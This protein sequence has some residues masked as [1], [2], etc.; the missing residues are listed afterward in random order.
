MRRP[1][2]DF[3]C[4]C[5][6]GRNGGRYSYKLLATSKTSTMQEELQEAFDA[7]FEYR[8]QTVFKST[9]GGQEV[10]CILER[11]KD[12]AAQRYD[13]KLLATSKTSN[14]RSA[15]MTVRFAGV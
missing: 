15:R 11:D 13:Y 9:S 3:D 8:G 6:G 12:A 5:D 14:D 4:F 7:G 1:R 2:P 10:V